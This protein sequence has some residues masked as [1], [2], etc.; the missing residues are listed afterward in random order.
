[1]AAQLEMCHP[2]PPPTVY[3]S[4]FNCAYGST[5]QKIVVSGI[6]PKPNDTKSIPTYSILYHIVLKLWE[7]YEETDVGQVIVRQRSRIK[8][9][10]KQYLRFHFKIQHAS[11]NKNRIGFKSLTLVLIF[12][13]FAALLNG[14][15]IV[16]FKGKYKS[17]FCFQN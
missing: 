11:G 10:T 8:A 7:L 9:T 13:K 14:I 4:S 15:N 2:S 3:L 5:E 17:Y 12:I 6:I 1:M 16:G